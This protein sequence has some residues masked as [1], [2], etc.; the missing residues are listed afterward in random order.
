MGGGAYAEAKFRES[1]SLGKLGRIYKAREEELDMDLSDEY[2]V[3]NE[4]YA[5]VVFDSRDVDKSLFLRGIAMNDRFGFEL[6]DCPADEPVDDE[7]REQTAYRISR[8]SAVI[9]A[10][11]E[12]ANGNAA[13]DWAVER[14][15]ESKK[16]VLGA[17]LPYDADHEPPRS[18]SENGCPVALWNTRKAE[19]AI[20]GHGS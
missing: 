18:V 20:A 14:S 8:A 9:V 6:V 15:L 11:T 2:I 4:K 12:N 19:A 5:L 17:R 1:L 3:R 7:W 16:P 13:I 10:V